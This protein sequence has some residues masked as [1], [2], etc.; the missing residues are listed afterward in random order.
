[1]KM[2]C[3]P[4]TKDGEKVEN[5]DV[6]LLDLLIQTVDVTGGQRRRD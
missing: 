3:C 6:R 5:N 2:G 1:L 4:G